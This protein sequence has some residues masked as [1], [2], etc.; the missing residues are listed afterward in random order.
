M[1]VE[2]FFFR[3]APENRAPGPLERKIFLP[4][5]SPPTS[6]SAARGEPPIDRGRCVPNVISCCG[7]AGAGSFLRLPQDATP[8]KQ[9]ASHPLLRGKPGFPRLASQGGTIIAR[10]IY[11]ALRS[12][13]QLLGS[14]T[15]PQ[16]GNERRLPHAKLAVAAIAAHRRVELRFFP[17]GGKTGKTKLPPCCDRCLRTEGVARTASAS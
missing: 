12:L 11:D 15:L 6:S 16:L 9:K 7:E 8:P 5:K 13:R 4:T 1:L 17:C 10:P 14:G 3:V 2:I